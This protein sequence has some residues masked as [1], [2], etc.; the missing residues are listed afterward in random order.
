VVAGQPS[1][2][3]FRPCQRRKE[4]PHPLEE[5][6]EGLDALVAERGSAL[7]GTAVLLAGSR[8]AGEDLSLVLHLWFLVT[9]RDED[10]KDLSLPSPSGRRRAAGAVD[11]I[12]KI[13]WWLIT[14]K[15]GAVVRQLGLADNSLCHIARVV[16][17]IR[18]NYA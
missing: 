14:G 2:W 10:S 18:D 13:F 8:V 9:V 15:P 1:G 7:L 12:A 16:G 5:H 4:N 17:C 3:R 6:Y 11:G